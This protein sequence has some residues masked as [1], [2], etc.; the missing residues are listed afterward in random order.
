ME[1]MKPEDIVPYREP[2]FKRIAKCIGNTNVIVG[3]AMR[4]DR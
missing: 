2:L 4:S 1:L 3:D